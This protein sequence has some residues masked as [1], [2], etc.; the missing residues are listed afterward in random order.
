MEVK[1]LEPDS[2]YEAIEKVNVI[3]QWLKKAQSWLMSYADVRRYE[4]EFAVG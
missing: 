4:L 1:L 3:V 2:V